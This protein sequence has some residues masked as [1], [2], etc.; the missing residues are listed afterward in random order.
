M[1]QYGNTKAFAAVMSDGS[2]QSWGHTGFAAGAHPAGNNFE[3]VV[4]NEAAFAALTDS[5]EIHSFGAG[6]YGGGH[7]SGDSSE[8][9][10]W[11]KIYSTQQ[12]FTARKNSGTTFS[13]GANVYGGSDSEGPTDSG[14]TQIV[15]TTKAFCAVNDGTG[16]THSDGDVHCWGSDNHAGSGEPTNVG[17]G[18]TLFASRRAVVA[19]K[20]AGRLEAWGDE[21]AGGSG[22]PV[23]SN[24]QSVH[25]SHDHIAAINTDGA[26]AVWPQI[27]ATATRTAPP[28]TL[29]GAAHYTVSTTDSM[30]SIARRNGVN[31]GIYCWGRT[32][33]IENYPTDNGYTQIFSSEF[34]YVALKADGKLTAW[35]EEGKGGTGQ[36]TDGG[37][38]D[39][40]AS[41]EAF[42]ALK[43]TGHVV[44][45]GNPSDGGDSYP[46]DGG[47]VKLFSTDRSFTALKSDGQVSAWG[48]SLSGA[49]VPAPTGTGF[50]EQIST[51]DVRCQPPCSLR[52][53]ARLVL[54][55]RLLTRAARPHALRSWTTRAASAGA[56]SASFSERLGAFAVCWRACP[57]WT[58]RR[59]GRGGLRPSFRRTPGCSL[60]G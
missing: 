59:P 57:S 29:P 32:D 36:P 53:S 28:A 3:L 56:D 5:G 54:P 60:P 13:W 8:G 16:S 49:N 1:H 26:L 23:S 21:G 7:T 19:L 17:S 58:R 27:D 25:A 34:S 48:S 43:D 4:P 20:S 12:A 44:A 15:A 51:W 35:G 10:G 41:S 55:D 24:W 37:Y 33:H 45:W 50:T 52:S 11:A 31:A 9:A 18:A 40:H 2:L 22:A 30:C 6:S 39:V 47:Y 38:V 42:A 46:T 14:W